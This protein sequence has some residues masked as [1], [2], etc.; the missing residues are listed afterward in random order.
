MRA[1]K[2]KKAERAKKGEA[3]ENGVNSRNSSGRNRE[4]KKK[5]TQFFRQRNCRYNRKCGNEPG[6]YSV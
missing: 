2:K 1:R 3:Q 6:N 5:E 4:G